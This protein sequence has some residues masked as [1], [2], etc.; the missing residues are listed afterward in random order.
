MHSLPTSAGVLSTASA[1]L[2]EVRVLA[3]AFAAAQDDIS[4]LSSCLRFSIPDAAHIEVKQ[5]DTSTSTGTFE[6]DQKCGARRSG[7]E[8]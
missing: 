3:P 7:R 8:G 5:F 1:L 2:D 4:Y 6:F